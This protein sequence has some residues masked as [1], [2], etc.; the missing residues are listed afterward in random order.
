MDCAKKLKGKYLARLCARG[1][2]Q[3]GGEQYDGSLIA[4]TV[5]YDTSICKMFVPML[6]SSWTT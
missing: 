1:Y 2:E 5:T 3:V 6:M 4:S